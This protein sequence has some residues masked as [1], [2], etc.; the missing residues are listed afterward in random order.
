M[1]NIKSAIKRNRQNEKRRV[2]NLGVRSKMRTQT[3]NALAAAG[4]EDEAARLSDAVKQIDKAA[5]KGILH[6]NAAARKK[7][8]LVKQI[9]V[10]AA[11]AEQG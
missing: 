5:N 2:A 8:R 3:K 11:A 1:A 9:R 7:S 10:A 6:K 4:T